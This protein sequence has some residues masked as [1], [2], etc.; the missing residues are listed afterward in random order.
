MQKWHLCFLRT[1]TPTKIIP[2][3]PR[4]VETSL[5]PQKGASLQWVPFFSLTSEQK[6]QQPPWNVWAHLSPQNVTGLQVALNV[7]EIHAMHSR[8][9]RINAQRR[10]D[11][12]SPWDRDQLQPQTSAARRLRAATHALQRTFVAFETPCNMTKNVFMIFSVYDSTM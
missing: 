5:R 2:P 12:T 8:A 4:F 9:C 11:A 10:R 7:N 1:R 3:R 6:S